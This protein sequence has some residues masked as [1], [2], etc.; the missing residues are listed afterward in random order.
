MTQEQ[1][2]AKEASNLP[3]LV[4]GLISEPPVN[5]ANII[6]GKKGVKGYTQTEAAHHMLSCKPPPVKLGV[7]DP[8][9]FS[10]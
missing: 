6:I 4:L 1:M 2:M 7:M 9:S 3:L 5:T 8:L 10:I